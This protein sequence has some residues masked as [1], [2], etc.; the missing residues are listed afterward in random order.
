MHKTALR[1][2]MS[3]VT[4]NQKTHHMENKLQKALEL[5]NSQEFEKAETLLQQFLKED[6]QNS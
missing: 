2:G 5:C 3:K 4:N 6:P 1:N